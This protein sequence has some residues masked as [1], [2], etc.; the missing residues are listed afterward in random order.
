[1]AR[2][3]RHRKKTIRQL[4]KD[5]NKLQKENE[6]TA[7]KLQKT[8]AKLRAKVHMQKSD[9]LLLSLSQSVGDFDFGSGA[10]S[11]ATSTYVSSS[12]EDE[13]FSASEDEH[14]DEK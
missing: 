9:N 1:M 14:E 6:L 12:S 11:L 4:S 7:R 10:T 5:T 8:F 13:Y 2:Q 3:E